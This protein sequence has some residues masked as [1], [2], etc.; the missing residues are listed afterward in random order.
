MACEYAEWAPLPLLFGLALLS[1]GGA[2]ASRPGERQSSV[3][4]GATSALLRVRLRGGTGTAGL[5]EAAP[6]MAKCGRLEECEP[7][8]RG[9]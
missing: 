4:G 2:A 9:R 1:V 3:P 6:R 5:D 8:L 7:V